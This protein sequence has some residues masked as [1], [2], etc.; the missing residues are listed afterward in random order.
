VF[1]MDGPETHLDN[2]SIANCNTDQI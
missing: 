1:W 2:A